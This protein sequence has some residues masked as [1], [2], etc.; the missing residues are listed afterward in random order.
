MNDMK[1][2]K[3]CLRLRG[4]NFAVCGEILQGDWVVNEYLV[5]CD[6]C[7]AILAKKKED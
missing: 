7:K 3:T 4:T 5:T 6:E 2:E 1:E